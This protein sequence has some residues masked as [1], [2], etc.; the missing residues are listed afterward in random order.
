MGWLIVKLS[1]AKKGGSMGPM[2]PPLD[3]PLHCYGKFTLA[4]W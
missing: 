3:P 2:E 1:A 4:T